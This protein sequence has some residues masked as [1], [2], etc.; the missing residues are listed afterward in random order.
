RRAVQAPTAGG[1]RCGSPSPTTCAW[2]TDCGEKRAYH[3]PVSCPS[4]WTVAPASASPCACRDGAASAPGRDASMRGWGAPSLVRPR[5][6]VLVGA[7]AH[8]YAFGA[9]ARADALV[10]RALTWERAPQASV[11]A[12]PHPSGA[13]TWLVDPAH[14]PLWHRSLDLLADAWREVAS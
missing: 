11:L 13:S 2:P 7:L 8:R 12:L 3:Q 5:I 1:G 10:G 9:H 6:V 14:V 4:R